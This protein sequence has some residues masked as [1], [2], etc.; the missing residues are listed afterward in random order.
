MRAYSKYSLVRLTE[1]GHDL[2]GGD[3]NPGDQVSYIRDANAYG[4]VVSVVGAAIEVL[5]SKEPSTYYPV[6]R[7]GVFLETSYAY[8]PY[9]IDDSAKTRMDGMNYTVLKK[10]DA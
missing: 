10:R 4:I 9:T 3:L 1:E 6:D 7:P 2:P 8:A 5:W